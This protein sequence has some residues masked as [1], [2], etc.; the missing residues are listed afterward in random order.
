MA[1]SPDQPRRKDPALF[2][3]GAAAVL[4][5]VATLF[6][7]GALLSACLTSLKKGDTVCAARG[8]WRPATVNALYGHGNAGIGYCGKEHLQAAPGSVLRQG[9]GGSHAFLSFL[10]LAA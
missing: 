1:Q 4:A 3:A 2:A 8:C 9:T 7:P 10:P 5:G 6:L